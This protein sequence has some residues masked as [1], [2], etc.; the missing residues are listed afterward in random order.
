MKL[1]GNFICQCSFPSFGIQCEMGWFLFYRFSNEWFVFHYWK[2]I[3]IG[4][5]ERN[6]QTILA[7]FYNSLASNGSLNW[8]LSTDLCGQTGVVCDSSI[9]KR[10]IQL[11]FL[12]L[13]L[14]S[15]F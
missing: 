11:Y 7:N 5:L 10:V 8:D 1:N 12:F 6:E 2:W 9:P 15:H 3:K 14:S 13:L 4:G